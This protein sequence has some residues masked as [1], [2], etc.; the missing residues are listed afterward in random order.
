MR[1][2]P[3]QSEWHP[4]RNIE[5]QKLMKKT[6][7]KVAEARKI[8]LFCDRDDSRTEAPKLFR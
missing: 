4:Q 8:R 5:A 1:S 7:V 2:A 3:V 6:E